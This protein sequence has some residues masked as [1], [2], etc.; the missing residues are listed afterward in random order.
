MVYFSFLTHPSQD[1]I[2][3]ITDL[4]QSE[5]WW[6]GDVDNADMVKKII[7]GSHCF[8]IATA[9][10]RIIGMGRAISDGVSDSYIQDVTVQ[11]SFRGQKIGTRIISMLIE[12]L[13]KDGI[14]WIGLI[15]EK[16]AS[17]F[18]EPLGFKIM[19]N[20]TPMLRKTYHEF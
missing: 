8:A 15:A 7:S 20:A 16:N 19:P 17:P 4:Y 6:E 9:E 13:N 3:E 10:D 14:Q 18:Y 2:A 5:K 1:Q 12:K 11:Q